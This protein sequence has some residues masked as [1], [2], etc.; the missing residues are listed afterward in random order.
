MSRRDSA[1]R[2]IVVSAAVALLCSL[3]VSATV[4]WLRPIQLARRSGEQDLSILIAAGLVANGTAPEAGEIIDRFLE[5][6]P[7]LVDLDSGHFVNAD[8]SMIAAY[9]YR[10]AAD[11][12]ATSRQIAPSLDLA[13]IGRRPLFMPVYLRY[14]NGMLDRIVLPMYGRGMWST[15]HAYLALDGSLTRVV[16]V[17]IAEHGETPGIGD[18]IASPEW[19]ARWSGKLAFD[20]NGSNVLRI[21]GSTETSPEAR[22]D[23]ITGAT[24]TV[25]GLDGMVRYWLGEDGY[26][27]FLASLRQGP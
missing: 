25:T 6:D 14:E 27:P 26:G 17:H 5:L 12:P 13:S 21:G 4:S 18:R 8:S 22:V 7:R 1:T 11:D 15:I 16:N 23:G 19:L 10:A 24:V 2:A 3:I 9:D 20:E